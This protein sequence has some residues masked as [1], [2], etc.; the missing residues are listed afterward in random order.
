MSLAND[1]VFGELPK[2]LAD[3]TW[4]EQRLIALHRVT[5]HILY[6]RNQDLPGDRDSHM[7]PKKAKAHAFCVPQDTIGTNE[8]LPPAPTAL[9]E[10]MQV[11]LLRRGFLS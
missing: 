10:I 1:L 8:L 3:L 6:F 5:I 4:A 9:P 7:A 11:M 2:E